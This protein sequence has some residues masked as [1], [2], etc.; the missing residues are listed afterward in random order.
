[1]SN[2]ST[3]PGLEH[4]RRQQCYILRLHYV[5]N[6]FCWARLRIY[7]LRHWNLNASFHRNKHWTSK[8]ILLIIVANVILRDLSILI[9]LTLIAILWGRHYYCLLFYRLKKWGTNRLLKYQLIT[10]RVGIP[11]QAVWL[12][13]LNHPVI[14][15]C[16]QTA[17]FIVLYR[18]VRW[19]TLH[20]L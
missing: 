1:M 20:Q 13:N 2:M 19:L 5:G 16:P 11:T 6:R 7:L 8:H 14:V 12:Q 10:G 9:L 17:C 4:P 15:C 18:Y 3:L